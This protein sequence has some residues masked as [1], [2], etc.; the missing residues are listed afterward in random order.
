VGTVPKQ[1]ETLVKQVEKLSKKELQELVLRLNKRVLELE[2]K[3]ANIPVIKAPVRSE[4]STG[5]KT[6]AG[7][8]MVKTLRSKRH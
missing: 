3:L 5:V 7:E 1:I 8:L 6:T 2:E 4:P